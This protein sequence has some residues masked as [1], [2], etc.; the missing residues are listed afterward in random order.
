MT[1]L[2]RALGELGARI[3]YPPTP[4]LASAVR[5]RLS[6]R[7]PRR[8]WRSTAIAFAALVLTAGAAL[9][10][11]P[12]RGAILDLFGLRGVTIERVDDLPEIPPDRPLTLGEHV[13]L[14]EARARARHPVLLPGLEGFGRPDAVYIAPERPGVPVTLVYGSLSRVRLLLTQ[15]VGAPLIEKTIGPAVE[16]EEV[17]VDGG[18]GAWLEGRH[19]VVFRDRR[20]RPYFE[21]PRIAGNTLLW[22][23]GALTLRLEADVD[24]AD[25]LRIARSLR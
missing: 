23:R 13:T 2:E 10:V 12:T 1:E 5:A 20:G 22:E 17:T 11:P 24:K 14:A 16:A 8:A 9:A 3:E 21:S 7:R 4:D 18:R 19:A 25:A 6:E 15:F